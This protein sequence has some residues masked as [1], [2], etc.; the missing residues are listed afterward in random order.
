[1]VP[2][3]KDNDSDTASPRDSLSSVSTTSIVFDR[4][5]EANQSNM[6]NGKNNKKATEASPYADLDDEDPLRDADDLETGP[7]LGA[8]ASQGTPS[9]VA[10]KRMPMDRKLRRILIIGTIVFVLGWLAAFGIFL[11]TGK[12][13]HLSDSEHDP[14]A[15]NR[16]SGKAVTLD[17]VQ[18][19]Y[20]HGRSQSISWIKD[21]DGNDGMLLEEGAPRKDYLLVEHVKMLDNRGRAPSP[22]TLMKSATFKY[23]DVELS[24]HKVFPSPDLKKV[25]L[26]VEFEKNWR[27]SFTAS[28]YILDVETQSVQPL[29]PVIAG[30]RIKV[31]N[32]SPTSDA[33]A[34]T[35]DDNNVYIR[36]LAEG[37]GVVQVT[38][39]GGVECFNGVPDWV[40]EEEVFSGNSAAWWSEDGKQLAFLRTNETG[41]PSFPLQYFVSRPS[42]TEPVNGEE[43]YPEVQ[44]I[45][46][47]KAGAHN[48]VVEVKFYDVEKDET[49]SIAEDAQFSPEDRI[50]NNVVWAGSSKVLVKQTNRVS[51]NLKVVL[52]DVASRSA[53]TTYTLDVDALDGGWFEIS[54]QMTYIPADKENGRPENGY[55]DVV[56][57]NGYEHLAYFSPLD[58]TEPTR[59][60]TEGEWEVDDAPAAIDLKKN[61]VYFTG[62]RESSIQRHVY[63]VN[64]VEGSS[65]IEP[66]TDID[67]EAFYTVSFSAE[68][69]F[70]LL[71]YKGPKIPIQRIIATPSNPEP[72]YQRIIEANDDLAEKAR[73]HELPVLKYGTLDLSTNVTVNYIERRPPHFSEKKR[74]P[75]LFQQYSG[76]GSQ[77]V[78][79]QFQVDYQSFVASSLGYIV[80]TVDPRGTGYLGRAHRVP[81]RGQLGVLEA[82]DHIAAASHFASLPYV[83]ESRLALWGWSYGGFQTLKT[84]EADAGHTFS[85]GMAVAPVTD[86]RFYDSVY[87]ERYMLLPDDNED[88]Y[89]A[90]SVHNVTAL[91]ENVRFLL[92]HGVADDNVHFQNSL[93]LLDELNVKGVENYDVHVFPDSDHSIYFHNANRIVYDSK[94]P[95]LTPSMHTCP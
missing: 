52:V 27:H 21:P 44:E 94:P 31:A 1:M 69:G 75:V 38:D 2:R 66:L 64:L 91:G 16:K 12:Y 78:K 32:W 49:F 13:H 63:S 4:I 37:G 53:K 28:Y 81:V 26:A 47:P 34:F 25:L 14:D 61:I 19:G 92:M 89:R 82:E 43:L 71:N 51:D 83:D 11:A 8:D 54:H 24:P 68:A 45:K 56:I 23:R 57:H 85:Y 60:L 65:S 48:P 67:T 33:I 17:Q 36:S 20:W 73:T 76:P 79:K 77:Q 39:D 30:A 6:A 40:Y 58:S 7:F 80:I 86:W 84:L 42:G 88:G 3:E 72:G 95:F 59:M 55:I 62:T 35:R 46:Y 41:V 10:V 5:H 22:R 74:Y 29:V 90:S 15:D 50:I 18:S 87:A 9:S 70:A 93:T